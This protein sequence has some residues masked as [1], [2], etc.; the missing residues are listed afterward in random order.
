MS[1]PGKDK[2]IKRVKLE[3]EVAVA[4]AVLHGVA[5]DHGIDLELLMD[6]SD[7]YDNNAEGLIAVDKA[8]TRLE[9]AIEKLN[10][11]K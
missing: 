1:F 5:K 3:T 2:L 8:L 7:Q 10:K 9:K 11:L 4:E 6:G